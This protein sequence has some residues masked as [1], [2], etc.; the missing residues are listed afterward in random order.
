MALSNDRVTKSKGP[1]RRK[2]YLMKAST[3]IYMGG[4][5]CL[6]TSRLAV[7]AADTAGFSQCVGV[8]AATVTSAASGDY[9][10]DV[11]A[12]LHLLDVGASITQP[13][14]GNN[15]V[16][17][18]DQTVIDGPASTNQIRVGRVQEY[19]NETQD[20]AWVDVGNC[21]PTKVFVSA[22]ITGDG[23]A[24]NTAH[25]LGQ[26]PWRVMAS[27]SELP[28]AAAETGF[29]IALGAHDATNVVATVT[30]TVKYYVIATAN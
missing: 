30:N 12:G 18:D 13:D 15:C 23:N 27:V 10:I 9:Y 24:D 16:V 19:L 5:V 1:L 28:D 7:P 26:V 8:A 2:R 29:D 25:G 6:D 17:S 21:A 20:K 22:E 11:D 4:L 3:T 14:V